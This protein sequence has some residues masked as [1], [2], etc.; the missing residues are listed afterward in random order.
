MPRSDYSLPEHKFSVDSDTAEVMHTVIRE[1]FFGR[2]IIAITHS[3]QS[4]L[5]FDRVALIKEGTIV[6]YG[7]P[8]DLVGSESEIIDV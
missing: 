3:L 6:E 7:Q 1:E 8:H 2:T 5:Y 4:F